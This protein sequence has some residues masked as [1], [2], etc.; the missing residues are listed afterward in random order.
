MYLEA[1]NTK[2]PT[3]LFKDRFHHRNDLRTTRTALSSLWWGIRVHG[4]STKTHVLWCVRQVC[5]HPSGVEVTGSVGTTLL[6][7]DQVN[8][9]ALPVLQEAHL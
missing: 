9:I 3:C 7:Y 2:F 1:V 4:H 5:D 6:D 8:G